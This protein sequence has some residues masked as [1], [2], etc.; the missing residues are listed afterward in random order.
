MQHLRLK[1]C[2]VFF[3]FCCCNKLHLLQTL[4]DIPN[5]KAALI[6]VLYYDFLSSKASVENKE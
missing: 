2:T 3:S 4:S 6:K 5:L 1:S